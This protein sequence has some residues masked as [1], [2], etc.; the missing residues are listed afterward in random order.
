[1]N[2]S[3][4]YLAFENK[5][6]GSS[7][8][9]NQK[10][11]FY[12]GLLNEILYRFPKCSLLDIG[13]GRG[14]WLLKCKKLGI[15]PTGID[16]NLSMYKYC[17]DKGL[18]VLHGDAL[19]VLKTFKDDSFQLI[20]SFHFIEHISFDL[21]LEVLEQSNRLLVPGGVLIL[22]TP[23]IDNLLVSSKNFYLDPSH[24]THI[25]P[26]A[27]KFALDY[28]NF[29]ESNYF[30]LNS[31]KTSKS[32]NNE[33][34][35][36]F[37]GAAQDV[38]IISRLKHPTDKSLFDE[39]LDWVKCLNIG[40]NTFELISDYDKQYQKNDDEI[41]NINHQLNLLTSQIDFLMS[42]YNRI[43]NSLP[44]KLYRKLKGIINLLKV[45]PLRI[46]KLSV[47]YI[48]RIHFL[49][50]VYSRLFSISYAIKSQHLYKIK[51]Y[52]FKRSITNKKSDI[53]HNDSK[54]LQLFDSNLRSKD[55]LSE[56]K[57]KLKGK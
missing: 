5:F 28:L 30:L 51:R 31:L 19:E 2:Y 26:E 32:E 55:I 15:Q 16:N 35:N 25:H 11:I 40:K 6:R 17:V 41:N 8:S 14:E 27:I 23:S 57:I 44:L 3:E 53:N 56:I 9:L 21:I 37:F 10:L 13:S 45:H 54:L 33:L 48:L 1:M 22:E 39:N 34:S 52:I 50:S 4:F 24:V 47:P 29:K 49:K 18:N 43:S 20:T 42:I 46:A 7:E 12:D 36:L 38:S